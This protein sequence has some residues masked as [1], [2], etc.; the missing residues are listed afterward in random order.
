MR[1]TTWRAMAVAASVALAACGPSDMDGEANV[2][3]DGAADVAPG[4]SAARVRAVADAEAELMRL[5]HEFS[6]ASVR[7]GA[8]AWAARWAPNGRHYGGG[9]EPGIGPD[10]VRERLTP[11]LEQTGAR[12]HW[13]PDTA[14]VAASGDLGY[15]LGRYRIMG[16]GA[17]AADTVGRGHYVTVWQK[18]SDGSW[19]IAVDI[20]T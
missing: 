7:E 19:K 14:V 8:A 1:E 20:G 5:E 2:D 18:Q 16:D 11:M 6:D 12:F 15:T 4:S 10:A 9:D 3:A 13:A 17:Q